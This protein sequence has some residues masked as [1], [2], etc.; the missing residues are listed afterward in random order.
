MMSRVG[1][2]KFDDGV[3][4]TPEGNSAR[5]SHPKRQSPVCD[6]CSAL[7]G[8][9]HVYVSA[10]GRIMVYFRRSEDPSLNYF[11]SP[12]TSRGT[13]LFRFNI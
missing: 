7:V 2:N 3:K 4:I 1:G 13:I 8:T 11:A 5:G 10:E 6:T 9:V 12:F